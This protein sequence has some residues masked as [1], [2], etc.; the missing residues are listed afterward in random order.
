MNNLRLIKNKKAVSG[1]VATV[2][3]IALV[4]AV[5]GVV[6]VVIN[7][8]VSE[9]LEEAGTCLDVVGK[10]NINKQYTC[11]NGADK[12]FLFS[13]GIGDIEVEK[14]IVSISGSGKVESYEIL[15]ELS[16]VDDAITSYTGEDNV[17]LPDKNEGVTYVLN[18]ELSGIGKPD[19][20]EISPVI[21][22]QQCSSSDSLS[23][24]TSCML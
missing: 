18:T 24:I 16:N 3:M 23:D 13:I 10:I 4:I 14:V 11:Y 15:K 7:N 1:V 2:F 19:L 20:I 9:Q 17:Q 5:V 8:L 6:W 21:K 22:G 12:Q